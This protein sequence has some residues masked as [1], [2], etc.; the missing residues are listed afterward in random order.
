MSHR[1]HTTHFSR[2]DEMEAPVRIARVASYFEDED[3][4]EP[5][6]TEPDALCDWCECGRIKDA[7]EPVCDDCAEQIRGR[8]DA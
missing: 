1:I 2:Y 4:P 5:E 3:E 8:R 6:D 7:N